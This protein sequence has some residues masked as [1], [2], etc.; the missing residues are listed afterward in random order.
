LL[1]TSSTGA[2]AGGNVDLLTGLD[3]N[4]PV[5][6]A[7]HTHEGMA[8]TDPPCPGLPDLIVTAAY[9]PP[10]LTWGQTVDVSFTVQNIGICPSTSNW[11]DGIYLSADATWDP[12]DTYL[13]LVL[14]DFVLTASGKNPSR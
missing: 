4:A 7:T 13:S 2:S 6:A 12:S 10:A 1:L 9:V 11:Y 8:A 5:A 3:S 14:T